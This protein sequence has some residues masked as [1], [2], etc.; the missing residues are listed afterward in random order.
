M[1]NF[2]S[3]FGKYKIYL[4]NP[5]AAFNANYKNYL[6]NYVDNYKR[7]YSYCKIEQ[8]KDKHCEEFHKFFGDKKYSEL[9]ILSCV[10][11]GTSR[12]IELLSD[13]VIYNLYHLHNIEYKILQHN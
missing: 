6:D 13:K 8:K 4:A 12:R 5:N 3:D 10:L 2:S 9:S 11:E 1:N 7:V